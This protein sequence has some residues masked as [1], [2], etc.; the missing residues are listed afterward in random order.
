MFLLQ[1]A[2]AVALS[3]SAQFIKVDWSSSKTAEGQYYDNRIATFV[4]WSLGPF[5]AMVF[6]MV[7]G[8]ETAELRIL[9]VL[10]LIS[11]A[12]TKNRTYHAI[13]VTGLYGTVFVGLPLSQFELQ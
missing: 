8:V 7:T 9:I 1:V 6:A 4:S 3:L 13:V 10:V 5:F 2:S 12:I 11:L